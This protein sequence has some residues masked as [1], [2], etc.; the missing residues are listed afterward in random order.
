MCWSGR[1]LDSIQSGEDDENGVEAGVGGGRWA[2]VATAVVNGLISPLLLILA[3]W[4]CCCCCCGG[5]HRRRERGGRGGRGEEDLKMGTE[6]ERGPRVEF[7]EEEEEEPG[8]ALRTLGCNF[9]IV[10][11]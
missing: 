3:T 10:R 9:P 1:C 11:F 5:R 2:I 6:D 8:A 7:P 4:C